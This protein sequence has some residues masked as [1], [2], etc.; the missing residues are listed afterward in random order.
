ML[1]LITLE[2]LESA[3]I[4]ILL[5]GYSLSIEEIGSALLLAI[6]NFRLLELGRVY[7]NIQ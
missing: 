5:R 7:R 6:A 1:L 2:S 3:S 4:L